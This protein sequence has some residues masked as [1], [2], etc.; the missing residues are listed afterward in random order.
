MNNAEVAN[1]IINLCGGKDNFISV[2]NCMTRL[3][4]KFKN[5]DLIQ[6]E[7]LKKVPGVLGINDA[8][9]FQI[10]VGPGK[11]TK[12]HEAIIEILGSEY[13]AGTQEET[14]SKDQNQSMD[15]TIQETKTKARSHTSG[16]MKAFLTTLSN[17]FV[18]VIPAIIASGFV[19]GINNIMTSNAT[20]TAIREGIKASGQLTNTQVVLQ[21]W[22]LLQV[23]T[24]F[25]I[26]G[27]AVLSFL[28]IYVGVTSAVQ[29]KTDKLLGGA[30]GA[31]T[32]SPALPALGLK[33]GEG[34]LFGVILGVWILAKFMKMFHKIIPD[35]LDVVLTPTLSLL[36][37]AGVYF[38]TVMPIMGFLS[39][40]LIKGI[41]FLINESGV[42]GGFVL[43]ALAPALISTGLHQGL[44]PIN[45]QLI[46]QHGSTQINAFQ[47]MSNA[48]LVGAGLALWIMSRNQQV[49]NVAKAALPATIL[50]V[51]EPTLFGLV[52]PSGFGFITASLGAGFGG[53]MVSLLGVKCSALG[54][55]GMS[56]IPLIADGKYI[57]YL[58][59][60]VVACAAGFILT[61]VVGKMRHYA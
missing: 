38:L 56:A 45:L 59:A 12:I 34:G 54:A 36:L 57:Q 20:N 46:A 13:D 15:Q 1:K 53:V 27:T 29:F 31:I 48:G 52:I 24:V 26:I 28:A 10:V 3:R 14:N 49:R 23:S 5:K 4:I 30:I 55:A 35:V 37:S 6:I 7:E 25:G 8:D 60:Y 33:A 51:G 61:Y 32:L 22:H 39:D 40:G 16:R 21:N 44:T 17:I 47:I 19:Q 9:T 42:V 50:A 11:S 18:P 58:I 41:L 2:E 43:S